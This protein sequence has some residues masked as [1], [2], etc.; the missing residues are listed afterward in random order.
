MQHKI[1]VQALGPQG[2][3]M[4]H[5]VEKCVHCGFCLAVCPTYRV[6]GDEND[7]PRGRILLMKS[8]LEG[9]IGLTDMLPHIDRCLG[10]LACVTACPSGVE[11]GHLLAPFRAR[12][13]RVRRRPAIDRTARTLALQSIPYPGRF[14]IAA[15]AGR[16]ARPVRRV[17]P[18]PLSAM[19]DQLPKSLEH[20]DPLPE[21]VPAEGKRRARVALLTGC[22]QEVLA[23]RINRAAARVLARN[24]VEVVIPRGQSCCG[25]LS[26]HAGEQGQARSL[27][28]TNLRIFPR[29][30]DAVILTAAGCGSGVQE[31]SL[32]FADTRDQA[33]AERFADLAR[34]ISVFLWELGIEPPPPLAT[35]LTAAYHDACHLSN[36]QRITAEPRRLLASIPNLT[37]VEIPEA[38]LCCG[39]AGTYNLEQPALAN[40]IGDRKAANIIATGADAVISGNIGCLNQIRG[41]LAVAGRQIRVW[42]TVELLDAAYRNAPVR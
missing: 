10:C 38:E 8:Q 35:P 24:G 22:V 15:R 16:L 37:L 36:A 30:V 34:D 39:S 12:S 21:I 26:Y 4:A 5:A 18:R 3:A 13:N 29:D 31:Y 17:L 28:R 40:E 20:A 41:R 25:S 1:P 6:L 27:A 32:L 7:S 19:I 14:R 2:E 42:H 23:P 11:Y 33:A 9:E